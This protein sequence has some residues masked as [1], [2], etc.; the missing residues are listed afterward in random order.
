MSIVYSI[1]DLLGK[2]H[3]L[4]LLLHNPWSVCSLADKHTSGLKVR[5]MFTS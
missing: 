2:L 5:Y 4:Y 1:P 3:I